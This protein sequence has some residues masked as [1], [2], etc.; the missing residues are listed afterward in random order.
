MTDTLLSLQ[1]KLPEET[2]AIIQSVTVVAN[3]LK[4]PSFIVGATARNIILEH[5]YK[6]RA[7]RATSDVDFGVALERWS[8]FE[9]LKKALI[10]REDF[11]VDLK[12]DQRLWR[13]S[14]SLEMKID[15]IPYGGLESPPGTIS[16]PPTGFEMNTSGF[17]EAFESAVV[18]Q[19]TDE[20]HARVV[21]LAGLTILK[22][23]AYHDRPQIRQT[24]LEDILFIA[25]NYLEA[26]NEER[27]YADT[28]LMSDEAFDLRTVGAR[29]LGRDMAALLTEESAAVVH[30]HLS[31]DNAEPNG[32]GLLKTAEV[33]LARSRTFE[34][35]SA[36]TLQILQ[37][38]RLGITEGS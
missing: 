22:F 6:V 4:M 31:E 38:L 2:I 19:L 10:D 30:R 11:R 34:E 8:D 20:I 37:Q 36:T 7:G 18:I 35:E 3:D 21:S 9:K 5:V 32:H 15:L 1:Q 16:F 23:I 28:D 24:D 33:M 25:K 26:G 27:L 12:M 29:L 14:G 17:K 13:R